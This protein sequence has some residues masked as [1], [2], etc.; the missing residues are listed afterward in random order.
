MKLS[1]ATTE[2]RED[3]EEDLPRDRAQ[4]EHGSVVSYPAR[5]PLFGDNRYRGNCD[6]RLFLNLVL[7]YRPKRV[8]DPMMG[9]GTTKD[10]ISWLNEGRPDE[11][12]IDYWGGDLKDGFDLR[13]QS[14]PGEFDLV[15]IHPPYWNIIRY[16]DSPQDLSTVSSFDEFVEALRECLQRCSQALAPG[17]RL[18]VLLG[19]V[20]RKGSYFP[21]V[22]EVMNMEG[23]LG[24]L[25]SVLI[26]VQ[27]N[28]SSDIR[29][30][31]LEDVPIR[32]EYCVVFKKK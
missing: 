31:R 25:R 3:L 16:S 7:H 19:D 11:E 32:H 13:C 6:G 10:V 4:W 12:K 2:G 28:C 15:F 9:S 5:S 17:G 8:A 14:I 30:Y 18:A 29:S 26:K 1:S 21:I 24:E 23:E 20:R 27:H 22:R